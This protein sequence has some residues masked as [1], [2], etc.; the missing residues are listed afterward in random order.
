MESQKNDYDTYEQ[1]GYSQPP[2]V[3]TEAKNTHKYSNND[4]NEPAKVF[5]WRNIVKHYNLINIFFF[6]CLRAR[7]IILVV[8]ELHTTVRGM[9]QLKNRVH[10]S[11]I[12]F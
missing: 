5:N 9:G 1:N 2:L 10:K 11:I 8:Y 7:I 6:N 3:E 4:T 12:V